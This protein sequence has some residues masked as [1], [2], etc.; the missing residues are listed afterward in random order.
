LSV[1]AHLSIILYALLLAFLLAASQGF[2]KWAAKQP[3]PDTFTILSKRTLGIG[4]SLAISGLVMLLYIH[5]LRSQ[6]ITKL[7]PAYTGLAIL[8][9]MLMGIVLFKEKPTLVQMI[10][11]VM[12]VAGVYLI[13]K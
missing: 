12:I 11:C 5:V 13:G 1:S 10:G 6:D 8:L 9:V 4:L 3:S 2:L 7:Y